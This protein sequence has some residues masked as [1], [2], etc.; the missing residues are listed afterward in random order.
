MY[1]G[2]R[3][4]TAMETLTHRPAKVRVATSEPFVPGKLV[5]RGLLSLVF[6][7]ALLLGFYL[8]LPA[9]SGP[10]VFDDFT[11]PYQRTIAEESLSTWITIAGVRPFLIFTYWVN[12]KLSGESPVGYHVLNLFIHVVNTVLVF[13]VLYRLLQLAGWVNAKRTAAAMA[14]AA[15]FLVHPLQTESVSYIAGR[16]ESLAALFVMLAYLVFLYRRHECISWRESVLVLVFLGVGMTTKENAIGMAGVFILTDVFWPTPFSLRGVRNNWRLYLLILPGAMAAAAVVLKM[17]VSSSSAGFSGPVTWYQYGFT[18]ARAIFT[19]LRLSLIPFDQSIDHDYPISHTVWEYGA[20]FY[21]LALLAV[22]GFCIV[23]RRRYPLTCFGLLMMLLLLAPTSSIVPISDPLVERR[24]Y[25]P[26][27]GL[28]L[29]GC[30]FSQRLRFSSRTGYTAVAAILVV[31]AVLCNDRN[32]LWAHPSQLWE[33]AAMQSTSKVRPYMNLVD[34]LIQEHRCSEAIPYLQHADQVFP[35]NYGVQMGWGRTLECVG[36]RD[37][38]LKRLQRAAAIQPGSY[39]YQLIGLLYGELGDH[40]A[41]GLSLQKAVELDPKSAGAHDAFGFWYET[42]ANLKAAEK[43]YRASLALD[44]ND[45]A[46]QAGIARV[47]R[48]IM[49]Q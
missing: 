10:F 18:Q 46:A 2:W 1:N 8:Y 6:I 44:P 24:M 11:L 7:A 36:R 22:V 39:V 13:L 34:Q 4:E 45:R 32:Q 43:E 9:L 21:L 47:A 29:I 19:Y 28:I 37:E 16:S 3:H 14:G 5:S 17:L 33:A 30:E 26:L 49:N 48:A 31:F 12:R 23:R 15:V 25:L 40:A 38:A 42:V 27:I 41:A 20:G 35:N